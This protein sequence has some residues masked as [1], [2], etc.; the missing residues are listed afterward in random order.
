MCACFFEHVR[1]IIHLFE[2]M[3]GHLKILRTVPPTKS[4]Q[5]IGAWDELYSEGH[6]RLFLLGRL[7]QLSDAFPHG[8]PAFMFS[9]KA[10]IFPEGQIGFLLWGVMN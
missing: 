8:L 9:L 7:L 3:F 1:K 4:I 6:T 5:V 2:C 10:P